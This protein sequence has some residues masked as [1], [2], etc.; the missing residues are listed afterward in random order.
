M[1]NP[2]AVESKLMA[3]IAKIL[4]IPR[5]KLV[6]EASFKN[7]LGAD[8]LDLV[9]LVYEIEDQLGITLSDD[10]AKKIVTVGDALRLAGQMTPK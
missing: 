10:D 5:E 7:D 4:K 3:I 2:E 1:D 8:S 6:A 9:M